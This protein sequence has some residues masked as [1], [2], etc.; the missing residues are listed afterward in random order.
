MP[1]RRH[2]KIGSHKLISLPAMNR[3][4]SSVLSKSI[5]MGLRNPRHLGNGEWPHS[6][7]SLREISSTRRI[8]SK[9]PSLKNFRPAFATIVDSQG[10][11][12]MSARTPD[13]RNRS[14]RS[15]TPDPLMANPARRQVFKWSKANWISWVTSL[16]ENPPT[17][18][19][20]FES[21]DE[22]LFKGGR[23]RRPRFLISVINTNGWIS[24][25]KPTN[26][27]QT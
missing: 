14:S 22:I 11:M 27:G 2:R 18:S 26:T 21:R 25:V 24:Q 15:R 12:L 3:A 1:W 4:S 5:L 7:T 16:F 6:R 13:S 19:F 17:S 20:T 9:C 23:L 8:S 10:I